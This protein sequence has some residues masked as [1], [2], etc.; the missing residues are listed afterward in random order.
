MTILE[1]PSQ[2]KP[3]FITNLAPEKPETKVFGAGPNIVSIGIFKVLASVDMVHPMRT[4]SLSI[5][6]ILRLSILKAIDFII[7]GRTP[8]LRSSAR[9]YIIRVVE[10]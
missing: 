10:A 7:P 4:S 3:P 8:E 1:I 9:V 5:L 2:S 6:G